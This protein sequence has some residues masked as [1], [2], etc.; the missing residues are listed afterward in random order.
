MLAEAM[1]FYKKTH[2]V[3]DR[4]TATQL[5]LKLGPILITL[6]KRPDVSAVYLEELLGTVT[7]KAAGIEFHDFGAM[8]LTST[9]EAGPIK[10]SEERLS[11]DLA[12]AGMTAI[13]ARNFAQHFLRWVPVRRL[14]S[15][16]FVRGGMAKMS[17]SYFADEAFLSAS[18]RSIVNIMPGG[19]DLASDFKVQVFPGEFG[20]H[21]FHQIDLNRINYELRAISPSPQDVTTAHLLTAFLE[22]VTDMTLAAHYG[23]D[24]TTSGISSAVILL[25]YQEILNRLRKNQDEIDSFREI[26]H[27]G[28]PTI[29]EVIDS[30]QQSFE[31]FLSLLDKSKKFREWIH[32]ANPDEGLVQEYF[33]SISTEHWIQTGKAKV[34]RYLIGQAADAFDSQLGLAVGFADAFIVEKVLKGWRP[35]HFID[36]KLAPFLNKNPNSD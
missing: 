36:N 7:R 12:R 13:E 32:S 1:L 25:R 22:A 20:H 2:I 3:F 18:L 4:L 9:Q 16:H 33:K 5:A 30:G 17:R 27:T 34:I 15:D 24:F 21:V 19:H 10:S 28:M 29:A 23:S 8:L 6:L 11:L 35:S 31:S 14:E 26:V